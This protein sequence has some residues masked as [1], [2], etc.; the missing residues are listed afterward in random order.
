MIIKSCHIAQFG[1]WKEKDFS[2]SDALNPYLWENGEGKTTLMHFFHIMFYGLSGDRKQDILENERKHFMPF[3]GGNFGGNIHF[4]E[5]GKN[6]ILERSFGLRKAEDSFRLLEEGGKESKDYSENIGE[7]IF[8]LDSEAFQKVCMISHEDLS[9]RFNSS[10][11]AK[12]GN[13]SD[14]REDMQKFQ[15]VQNTLK[16]AINALSPNR[17]TG[18]IFKKKMEEE[19]LSASLYRKKEEEEAVLSLEEEVLSLEEQWKEK[20]KEE[21]R[22][23]EEVQKGIVEKE[24]LGKKVEY[25]KLQEELEKAHY[26]YEN[27]KKW[28]YQN[29]LES[30]SEEEQNRLWKEELQELKS[31]IN[32]LKK[33]AEKPK[34]EASL[35][36]GTEE[37]E[38]RNPLIYILS[39]T[40]LIF[41][42]LFFFKISGGNLPVPGSLSLLIAILLFAIAFAIYYGERER[43]NAYLGRRLAEEEKRGKEESLR[44]SSL[45]ELLSHY[46]KVEEMLSLEAEEKERQ[47]ALSAFLAQGENKKTVEN[48]VADFVSLEEAQSRLE[49]HRKEQE[50]LKDNIREKREERED[51]VEIL[52][53][54]SEQERTLQAVREERQAMEERIHILQQTKDYLE[55]AKDA[56]ASEYRGPILSAFTKYFQELTKTKMQFAITN[57]L[58]IEFIEGGMRRSLAYLSEGLQDLCRF[59]MKLAIFDA[60]FPDG[61]AVLFLDD[62]YSHFDDEKGERGLALLDGLSEKRQILY[63]TCSASRMP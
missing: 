31:K 21:E 30:L 6:Y 3:Q 22:L 57:D 58:E 12:L 5:K 10:I 39:V 32:A 41:L 27:A 44:L 14:D 17:R 43:R 49:R 1:K 16:D 24:A 38:R 11:H 61:K 35:E 33:E 51:R 13:V 42:L 53:A 15:K 59:A 36:K 40:A 52:K 26:R 48:S 46:H 18:A 8:S 9:L 45:E 28:Y 63:F 60:M 7:E 37:K 56:F 62:P 19:S 54:L 20:T 23:E 25:Q 47:E 34:E 2:F 55:K 29:R 4:Q 50:L